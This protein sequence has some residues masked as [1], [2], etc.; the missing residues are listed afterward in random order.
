ML[1]RDDED[2]AIDQLPPA[3]RADDR[4]LT[5]ALD[6][7][8]EPATGACRAARRT[9]GAE[10]E[11]ARGCASCANASSSSTAQRAALPR[12]QL[13][14]AR[15]RARPRARADRQTRRAVARALE[16][17]PAPK[18][19]LLGRDRDPH[20]VDRTRL[21]SALDG[22]DDA[23]DA[24]PRS[25]SR[26][27]VSELG[28]PEQI[29]SELDGLDRDDPPAHQRAR[30]DSS[31]SS[32]DRELQAPGEWAH[33]AAR[34]TTRRLARR[35]LGQRACAASRAT[36]STT[37]ITDHDRPARPRAARPPTRP[38]SGSAP[39]KPWSGPSDASA[40]NTPTNTTTASTSASEM[41][42]P[43]LLTVPQVAAEFQVTAQTIRN[44]IDHGTLPAVRIGRA[45]RVKRA[46]RRRATRTCERRQH[47]AR[48]P[49]RPLAT[50]HHDAATPPRRRSATLDL[51]RH[52]RPAAE[53]R[54]PRSR[55]AR[56]AERRARAAAAGR[57]RDPHAQPRPPA[58]RPPRPARRTPRDR[59]QVRARRGTVE[60]VDRAVEPPPQLLGPTPPRTRLQL[61][62]RRA[63]RR[64]MRRP[65]KPAPR[66]PPD[67]PRLRSRRLGKPRQTAR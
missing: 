14:P 39:T 38:A 54:S 7:A 48:H 36:A 41:A 25:R 37:T 31:T 46:G 43:K 61:I 58:P 64:P 44:W 26:V 13:Q 65:L 30:S 56:Y 3:G 59:E 50:N 47:L 23:I 5:L 34:R 51:G 63:R 20:L 6:H 1:E 19:S 22:T 53:P 67:T 21:T 24:R 32:T 60:L 27:C 29:R 40:A 28:D 57:S 17:L 8:G 10:D 12:S 11:H 2:L 55:R 4:Q 45:F 66:P 42:E 16:R 15:R 35:G 49:P 18:R 52:R 62:R 9:G 33:D